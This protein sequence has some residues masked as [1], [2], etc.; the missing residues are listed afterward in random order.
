[1]Y[2]DVPIANRWWIHFGPLLLKLMDTLQWRHNN[3]H[4]VSNHQP[5]GCLLNGL[6][7][8]RS[9]KTSQICVTG[10]C[11]GN[12]ML[13]VNS[14]HKGP[15]TRKMFPSDDVIMNIWN[16]LLWQCRSVAAVH[17]MFK[18]QFASSHCYAIYSTRICSRIAS[19]VARFMGSTWGPSE[20]DRI[21]VGPMLAP[22]TLLTGLTS[23]RASFAQFSTLQNSFTSIQWRA[24]PKYKENY[25]YMI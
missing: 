19:L 4:G 14:P 15:V 1:M 25:V 7:K 17:G 18:H 8:R 12:S 2:F 22:W 6:F 20:V 16:A 24:V 23:E 21:H 9:K 13:P 3:R 11:E 5:H 10:L